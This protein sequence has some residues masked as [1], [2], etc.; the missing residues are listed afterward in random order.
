MNLTVKEKP[1][2]SRTDSGTLV[3]SN[4]NDYQQYLQRK[5]IAESKDAQIGSLQ[6]TINN[7]QGKIDKLE[8]LI[9]QLINKDQ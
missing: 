8:E 7:M 9:Q 2:W 3:N 6:S 1:D 5:K 4:F